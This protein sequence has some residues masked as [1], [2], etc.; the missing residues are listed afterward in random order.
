[1][2]KILFTPNIIKNLITST[3]VILNISIGILGIHTSNK[4]NLFS[5]KSQIRPDTT[6]NKIGYSHFPDIY[7][8]CSLSKQDLNK[9]LPNVQS[10]F[11]SKKGIP[12]L[13][14]VGDSHA[15]NCPN[16]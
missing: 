12:D 1:M 14:I 4:V 2:Q 13:I 3:L 7:Y 10:C 11:Q 5:Q 15:V 8:P 9:S 6:Q 16:F